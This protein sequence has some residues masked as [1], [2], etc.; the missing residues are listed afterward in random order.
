M[1]LMQRCVSLKLNFLN[2][3]LHKRSFSVL[4]GALVGNRN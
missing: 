3:A 1:I 4:A 2:F